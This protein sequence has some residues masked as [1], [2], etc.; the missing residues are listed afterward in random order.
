MID[1]AIKALQKEES[2]TSVL[3]AQKVAMKDRIESMAQNR[4]IGE[5]ETIS[6]TR[7]FSGR[8]SDYGGPGWDGGYGGY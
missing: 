3:M 4:D 1:A 7:R 8:G 6:D 2:D 5:C